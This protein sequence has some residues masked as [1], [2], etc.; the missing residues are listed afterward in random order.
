M[1]FPEYFL[2]LCNIFPYVNRHGK[3]DD[4]ALDDELQ[5]R[6]YAQI[7]QAVVDD[8]Q[9][10]NADDN[11]RDGTDTAVKRYAADN[12]AGNRVKVIVQAC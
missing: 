11:A 10:D 4:K 12:A 6:V 7:V 8:L 2:L 1:F 5:V 9:Y 3:D